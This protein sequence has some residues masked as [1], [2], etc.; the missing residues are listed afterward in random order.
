MAETMNLVEGED[1][2]L[3]SS[4]AIATSGP[5][6]CVCNLTT[7]PFGESHHLLGCF[8]LPSTGIKVGRPETVVRMGIIMFIVIIIVVKCYQLYSVT[9]AAGVAIF[10]SLATRLSS[11]VP[12]AWKCRHIYPLEPT[13]TIVRVYSFTYRFYA[14]LPKVPFP[15]SPSE[16]MSS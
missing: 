4:A 8:R 15:L 10:Q 9:E 7:R 2:A 13:W 1:G 16:E 5:N 14:L 11:F 3:R 6:S 12:T